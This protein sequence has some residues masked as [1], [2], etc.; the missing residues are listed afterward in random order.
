MLTHKRMF[1]SRPTLL[2]FKLSRTQHFCTNTTK[3]TN[4][5]SSSSDKIESS[6]SKYYETYRQLDKLDFMTAAKIVFSEPPKQ[7]KFG[8][9]FHLVQLFF[10][11]LPSLAVYMVAQYARSEMKKMD[12]ELELKKREE[13]E[14]AKEMELKAI[15]EKEA[16]SNPEL[17]EVKVRLDK[18]EEAV[19]EIAV[20]SKKQSGDDALK[21]QEDSSKEKHIAPTKSHDSQSTSE[22]SN[23]AEKAHLSKQKSAELAPGTGKSTAPG[24]S[25]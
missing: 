15:E 7:K 14:K 16:R 4:N 18:L 11:C 10:A 13:E 5:N 1:R 12:A 23:S 3:P 21:N 25:S 17:L 8:I 9:D 19:K 2:R 22:S 24:T 6:I 20:E